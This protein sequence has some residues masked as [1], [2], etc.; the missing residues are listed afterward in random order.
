MQNAKHTRMVP[1][2]ESARGPLRK[3]LLLHVLVL[4]LVLLLPYLHMPPKV[5]PP[6][7]VE[8]V[9]VSGKAL[10]PPEPVKPLPLPEPLPEPEPAPKPEPKPEPRPEP[11]PVPAP[12]I[13]VPEAT[14]PLPKIALPK[15]DEKKPLPEKPVA[16]PE[17]AKPAPPKPLIK[18]PIL[19][20]DDMDAEFRELQQQSMK[21]EA[22][23]QAREADKA[24]AN[25][26]NSANQAIRD[27]YER[28]INQRVQTKWNRPLSARRGMVV[29]LRISVLPGGEVSN[30][31]TVK[32]SGDAAFD[33]SAEEAVRRANPLPVPDDVTAFNQYFRVIT[34]KFNPE[35][36]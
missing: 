28:L 8:A 31:V 30:V 7:V 14:K 18:A 1:A 19:K 32:S 26:R 12:P 17:P 10:T 20:A 34:L 35:D 29:T 23:R 15:V 4:G 21:E 25:A 22:D 9:L 24:I 16:K 27:K 13:K 6:R 2:P 33:A 5:E 3:S 11:K 36:L